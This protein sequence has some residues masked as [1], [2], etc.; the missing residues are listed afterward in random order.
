MAKHKQ[1]EF[2]DFGLGEKSSSQ[3]YRALN[4][5]GS[6]NIEKTN[7]SFFERLN[8]F[9]SLV[10][11]K[12]SHF[13]G[14]VVLTYLLVNTLFAT[15]YS[16]IG[17][18]HLTGIHGSSPFEQFM[19]AFF[20]SAQTITTLGYGQVAPLGLLANIVA[21]TESLLGLLFFALATGLL[22][23]RFSKPISKIKF[24]QKAII[25]P[26]QDINGFM[27]RLVNPQK[28]ELLD[29][30]I[31]V[32]V[33]MK[34]ENSELRDFHILNLER[35]NVRFFPS[36]WTVVHPI[37]KNSPLYGL[38]KNDYFEKDFEFIAMLKAFDESSGQ[39]V[40]SRSSYKPE[41]IEWGQKFVYTA[42]RHN[43][44]LLVDV[45]RINESEKAELN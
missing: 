21:A 2:E 32:S 9:H 44:K 31:N 3:G 4:K 12:W 41:E 38:N 13:F 14:V 37:D 28:N 29:V 33:S 43:G 42:K 8:F 10:T 20:F 17:I 40:Y 7:I 30:E 15:I 34:R 25:A 35:D 39:M 24:S 6:F 22:Y 45:G 23:G 16:L 11:M 26:Y 19:E 5:D 36:M 18:E 27:F 1:E